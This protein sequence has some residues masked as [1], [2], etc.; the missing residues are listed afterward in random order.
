M[1]AQKTKFGWPREQRLA[2]TALIAVSALVVAG[3][4]AAVVKL[5][6]TSAPSASTTYA[7]SPESYD[8]GLV[9]GRSW[10]LAGDDGSH[11]QATIVASNGLSTTINGSYDEVIPKSV[12]GSDSAISFT[13]EPTEIVRTDPVVRYA[14]RL[15]PGIT[16]TISYGVDIGRTKGSLRDSPGRVWRS[17]RAPPRPTTSPASGPPRRPR[18]PR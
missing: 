5:V 11:L 2:T 8:G 1:P 14:Y 18:S 15:E 13:P 17:T 6:W 3:V 10:T 9:I 7:F 12:A 16:M 4:A